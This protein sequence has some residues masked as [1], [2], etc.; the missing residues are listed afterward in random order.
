MAT[1]TA[2]KM[3]NPTWS[4]AQ[5][6]R[7][8]G[9]I[10]AE[11]ILLV[12]YPGSATPQDVLDWDDHYDVI[13][14]LVD[15]VLVR[16]PM[17]LEESMLALFLAHYLLSYLEKHDLGILVG[18]AGFQEILPEQIRAPDLSFISWGRLPAG[19]LPKKRIPRLCPDLAVEILS[20]SNTPKEMA[21]KRREYF[22]QGTRLVWQIDPEKKTGHVY[23]AAEASTV[24]GVDDTLDGGDV[25]PGFKLK[26]AKLFAPRR[27]RRK[28]G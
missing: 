12:P 8:F 6:R 16:K 2:R 13:C 20:A 1:A 26:L 11:R 23:T 19:Q 7:H 24:L 21:R 28:R 3:P 15:G 25:L 18:E 4:Y 27:Q 17:G 5:L 9:M 10:P 22:S 14:E